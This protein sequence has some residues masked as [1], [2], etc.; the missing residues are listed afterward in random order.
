MRTTLFSSLLLASCLS[1]STSFA[2]GSAS[3]SYS[4]SKGADNWAKLDSQYHACGT[5][6]MQSPIDITDTVE[7]DL[8]PLNFDYSLGTFKVINNGHTIQVE[9]KTGNNITVGEQTYALKQF[10]FHSPSEYTIDGKSY[11]LAMHLVHQKEDG[12]LGVIA[13]LFEENAGVQ[14][15]PGNTS[16]ANIW[17]NIPEKAGDVHSSE[18]DLNLNLLLPVDR[19]YYRLM[20]SLTTPPCSEGVNWYIMQ[21]PVGISKEQIKTFQQY[22]PDSARP[23]QK[24]HNRLIIKDTEK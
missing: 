20:G 7:A 10:H 15:S 11:P 6:K 3:W 14:D 24:R 5:G 21:T 22:Y 8:L 17:S 2:A 1:Y 18:N 4:G 16:I 12:T 9:P 19:R 23:I 13:V